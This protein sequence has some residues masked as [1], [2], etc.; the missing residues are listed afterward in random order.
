MAIMWIHSVASRLYTTVVCRLAGVTLLLVAAQWREVVTA[1][2]PTYCIDT[3]MDSD[4]QEKA[5]RAASDDSS[6]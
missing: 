3:A 5:G 6:A 2:G 1:L 4:S